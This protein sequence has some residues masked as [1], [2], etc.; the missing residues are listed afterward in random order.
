MSE[1]QPLH[2]ISVLELATGIAGP[3]L[4]KLLGDHGAEVI[5]VEPPE[6]DEA[7]RRGP[8]I[9]EAD[10]EHSA[11]FLHLNTNKRSIVAHLGST[12]GRVL[13]QRLVERADVVIESFSRREAARHGLTYDDL[14]RLNPNVVTVSV[15]TFGR[16]GPY[17]DYVGS[18]LVAYAVGGPLS[19]AGISHREPLHM[20]NDLVE[21]QCGTIG[22]VATLGALM[23]AEKVGR[24]CHIDLANVDTQV[25]TIDRR[26]PFLLY[27]SFT[28]R[29]AP[30][31]GSRPISVYPT[32]IYPTADGNVMIATMPRWISR[33]LATLDDVDLAKRYENPEFA[34][35]PELAELANTAVLMWTL[36]R[37]SREAMKQAQ[38]HLWP[39]TAVQ[40]PTELL[41]DPHF[42]ARGFWERVEHPTA[43]TLL[44][45]GGPIRFA[46]RGWRIA[47]PAPTIG[48]HTAEVT[49]ELASQPPKLSRPPSD[50]TTAALPLRGVR[51]IDLTVIWSGPFATE[52][53]GD[54]G[55]E[56]IR[57]ENPNFFPTNSRGHFP[58]PRPEVIPA[59]GPIQGGY[60]EMDPGP[61]PWN[62]SA[63]FA[64]HGRNKKSITLDL[65]REHGLETFL[66]LVDES[67][68]LLENNRVELL[69]RLG[70]DWETL[71]ARNPRLIMVRMPSAGLAGPYADYLGFG[72]SFEALCGLATVR[73]YPD[74]DIGENDAVYHMDA[75]TGATAAFATLAALRRRG[76][77]GPGEHIEL[78]QSENL[79][80]QIGPLLLE[81]QVSPD[82]HVTTGNRH[83]HHGP[84]GI[85]RCLDAPEGSGGHGRVGAAGLDR[86]VAIDVQSDDEWS[87][88]VEAMGGPDWASESRMTDV[89]HRLAN[90]DGIDEGI[91]TWTETMTHHEAF[92]LLQ[93]HGIRAGAVLTESECFA[94]EH[95]AA[96]GLF[97][98]N[99]NADIG[100][101]MFPGHLW[102]WTGPDLAW[103]QIPPL[104]EHNEE[105]YRGTLGLSDG[106]FE[107]LVEH[108]HISKDYRDPNGDAF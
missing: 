17:A 40:T 97:R 19:S 50:N 88:L 68:V 33:M 3:H 45:P 81:A 106:E 93:S 10:R 9:G 49:S 55:A 82:V 22:A 95:L 39:V 41:T 31:S 25:G 46:N 12:D 7:R 4:G 79:L 15:T 11:T 28:G 5:K 52:L 76:A 35:D 42:M 48:Q 100:S 32:G 108:G 87:R 66:R 92:H 78:A 84:R 43:G 75:T 37:T 13:V 80:N 57:V 61:R 54:L 101:Y 107:E 60:P 30:R 73:G 83:R 74:L 23:S 96:R 67:D 53:L 77:D 6:G 89:D 94:D 56:V 20:G 86:W 90:A 38:H 103:G 102:Q 63:V 59:I 18:D 65:T 24:P 72:S 64:S 44:Y 26:A 36:Q 2:G 91:E 8:F 70:I 105:I 51:I 58:R 62:R 29:D 104:G 16:A 1:S 85:Y 98:E 69:D 99:G 14:K 27:S 71:H 47:T 34:N 21:L